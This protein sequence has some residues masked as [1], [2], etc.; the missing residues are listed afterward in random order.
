VTAQA[1]MRRLQG[2]AGGR[3]PRAMRATA[4]WEGGGGGGARGTRPRCRPPHTRSGRHTPDLTSRR[5]PRPALR[6]CRRRS[7]RLA[8]PP[9]PAA[10][11]FVDAARRGRP[12]HRGSGGAAG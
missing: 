2:R 11:P 1:A 5:S 6:R 8:A 7:P 3:V 12:L 10:P 9:R 4:P